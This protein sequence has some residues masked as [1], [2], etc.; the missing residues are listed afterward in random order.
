M[1]VA[2][3]LV[4]LLAVLGSLW[5]VAPG[6]A[7]AA[8]CPK[9]GR[10]VVANS[11]GR[12]WEVRPESGISRYYGCARRVGKVF[13]LDPRRG[14]LIADPST[15]KI[16]GTAVAYET[17]SFELAPYRIVVRSLRTGRLVHGASSNARRSEMGH[18]GPALTL[19]LKRNGTVA[20]T[21]SSECICEGTPAADYEVHKI[22]K[23]HRRVV[24]D[25]GPSIDPASLR[26]TPDRS[27]VS[28]LDGGV[29]QSAALGG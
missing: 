17:M 20:W 29:R 11:D 18:T 7:S 15:T 14:Q 27:A 5:A 24:V 10:T 23:D 26:F 22:G 16:A 12:V 9:S 1:A 25:R 8:G 19:L 28:W 4:V 2:R 21:A 6:V 3:R 13:R